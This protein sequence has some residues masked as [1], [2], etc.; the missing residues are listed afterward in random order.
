M[1]SLPASRDV[2]NSRSSPVQQQIWGTVWVGVDFAR[3]D[4]LAGHWMARNQ[5]EVAA[6]EKGSLPDAGKPS[7]DKI[8]TARFV[9]MPGA[10][11]PGTTI[12]T[13]AR[14]SPRVSSHSPELG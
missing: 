2:F 11:S 9:T 14:R 13:S 8:P 1:A 12:P 5:S 4:A 7:V 3:L 10:T 6:S